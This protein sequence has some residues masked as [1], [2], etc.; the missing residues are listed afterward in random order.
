MWGRPH[1]AGARFADMLHHWI[2]AMFVMDNPI[3]I[4]TYFSVWHTMTGMFSYSF[5]K[6]KTGVPF[7]VV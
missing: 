6:K 3:A 5:T 2:Y 1:A 4:T 7:V